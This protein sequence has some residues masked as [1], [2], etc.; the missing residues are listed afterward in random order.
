MIYESDNLSVELENG[1]AV[2]RLDVA[3][4]SVNTLGS[5]MIEQL[6]LALDAIEALSQQPEVVVIAS[7][8]P[9]SFINGADLFEM[10]TMDRPA[11]ERYLREGQSLMNRLAGLKLPTVATIDGHCLGGGLELAL[12]C[13][14]RVVADRG[15]INLGLPEVRLGIVPA[16]GGTT[17][18]VRQ[19]GPV[20][21]LDLMLN[22]RMLPPRKARKLGLVDDTV[23][24]EA[25]PA[26]ARRLASK[27]VTDRRHWLQR[28]IAALPPLAALVCGVA[29]RRAKKESGGH[30]PAADRLI[31]VVQAGL[32]H[33]EAAGFE[34]ERAAAIELGE[35]E[36][37]Q[38]LMR[39]FFLRHEA[40][41]AVKQLGETDAPVQR[42]AV[43]G[44]GTMGAGIAAALAQNHIEVHLID[45][46]VRAAGAGKKRAARLIDKAVR[47]NRLSPTEAAAAKRRIWP[48]ADWA[49]LEQVDLVIEAA[50]EKLSIKSELFEKL[51]AIVPSETV[52][53]TNTSSL[54]IARIAEPLEDPDRL[55]GLHFFNPV[56]K[57]PL[58]EVV[59]TDRSR[60]HDL[61]V[62][63]ETALRLG[64]TP[65]L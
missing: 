29:R 46:D 31:D 27:P 54:S 34:A 61:A 6:G 59:R 44:G 7:N 42:A 33:G 16:W 32:R 17:R 28:M 57:M 41:E 30:Y 23:R 8:K 38:N 18:L 22:G 37:A 65:I 24:A 36:V 26:A 49:G 14:H 35:G 50:S 55:I 5:A 56:H 52:L 13:D 15:S 64:K 40:K 19:V 9:D 60:P 4:R 48:A 12:A 25:L 10:R 2:I 20:P 11:I 45:I 58:V 53:A 21:A 63:A 62:A 51:E 43:I 3:D 39:L 47:A 1:A